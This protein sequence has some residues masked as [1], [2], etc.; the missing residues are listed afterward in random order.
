MRSEVVKSDRHSSDIEMYANEDVIENPD[1]EDDQLQCEEAEERKVLPT[2]VLPS[3]AEIDEHWLD[4]LPYR[5]WC[6]TCVAGRG[7]ERPHTRTH[8]KR[9]IPTLA[10]DYCF[11]SKEGTFTREEWA[12][13]P[14][15]A[16]GAKILVVREITSKCTF[17]HLVK[18]KGVDDDRYA[19]DCLVKD[20]EWMGFTKMMLRSDNEPAI[21]ALLREALRSL[22][23]EI[24]FM[25]QAAEE[26]PPEYDPQANGAIEST[27]GAFKG[28]IRTYV[29]SLESR[30]GFRI[31]PEHPIL[32]WL[33]PHTA[34]M[35]TARINAEDGKTAYERVRLRPFGTRMLEFGEFCRHT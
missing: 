1:A 29:L 16:E 30:L 12:S 3:Q 18:C 26:H 13:M 31:P 34:F 19:V 24:D 20:I 5:S 35:M 14:A 9:E 11:I 7:R 15:D 23:V 22:R 33:V 4:H 10:F 32:A 28:Q 2:P 17:A 6:G 21:V 8:G 25:E 27:V